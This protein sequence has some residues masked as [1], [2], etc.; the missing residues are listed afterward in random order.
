MLRILFKKGEGSDRVNIVDDA[1]GP[2]TLAATEITAETDRREEEDTFIV[3]P[4]GSEKQKRS[5][6]LFHPSMKMS[7]R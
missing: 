2:A 7:L 1:N 6:A 5:T 3:I 4:N